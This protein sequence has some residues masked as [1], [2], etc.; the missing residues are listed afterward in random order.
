MADFKVQD[1]ILYIGVKL[2]DFGKFFFLFALK[3]F[4]E[5]ENKITKASSTNTDRREPKTSIR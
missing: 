1:K 5:F 2:L 4:F 3:F